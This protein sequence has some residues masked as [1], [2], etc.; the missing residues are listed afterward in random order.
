MQENS[1]IISVRVPTQTHQKIASIAKDIDRS[2]NW[3]I[4]QAIENYLETYDWQKEEIIKAIAEADAG[5]QFYS[6]AEMDKV[7]EGFKQ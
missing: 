6:S 5:G 4:N 3:L 1:N 7:I 2:Q